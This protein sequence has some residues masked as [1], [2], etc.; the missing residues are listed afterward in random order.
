MELHFDFTESATRASILNQIRGRLSDQQKLEML[1]AADAAGVPDR[2]QRDFEEVCET[3][4]DLHVSDKVKAD[5]RAI[6]GILAQAEATVHGTSVERT[7]FHEVGRA[8]GV[9]NVC[10]I[11]L[12]MET[13][14]PDTVTATK[15]QT[16]SGTVECA[17]GVLDIPAP[18]TAAIIATGIPTCE[19]KGEGELLTPTSAAIIK[20]FV[21]RFDD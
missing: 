3:I 2:D 11:C 13:L 7:H 17:H 9:K 20:H 16:G 18:A 8:A 1:I 12:A 21:Q 5:M 19:N 15:V 14:S 10:Q 4:D 6:Y